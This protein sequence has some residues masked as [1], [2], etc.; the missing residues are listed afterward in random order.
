MMRLN[1]I[2]GSQK[3]VALGTWFFPS[4]NDCEASVETDEQGVMRLWLKWEN[5]PP[6]TDADNEHYCRIVLQ[7]L[8]RELV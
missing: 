5:S 6:L 8:I 3:M 1:Y 7:D 4:G 2:G